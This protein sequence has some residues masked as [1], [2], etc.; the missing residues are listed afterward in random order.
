MNPDGRLPTS[1]EL[2]Y[3]HIAEQGVASKAELLDRF[4]IPSSTLTRT[5][6]EMTADGLIQASGLGPSSGGRRPI[7]YETN[8][9]YGYFFGLEISRFHSSLGFFDVRMNPMSFT[10]WR[11]DEAMTPDKLIA[12]V[13]QTVKAILYDHKIEPGQ[14]RGIGIGAVGPLDRERG[15]VLRP[16]YFAAPGWQDVPICRMAEE[17]T[18]FAARLENGA[19]A[20]LMGERWA[21]RESQPQHMLYVHAGVGLRSALMSNGAVVHGSIDMEGAVG[22]MIVQ[23]DGPRLQEGG[24]FGALEAYASIQA[25]EKQARSLAKLGGGW[26][27]RLRLAPEQIR[28]EDLLQA[29]R[30]GYPPAVELF[31]RA[32]AYLGIGLANMINLFHPETVILGGSLIYADERFY[33]TAIDAARQNVY[34]YP[35]YQPVF[36]KGELREDAVATGAAL[37]MWRSMEI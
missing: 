35:A 18:G 10:R 27:E 28:Y 36:T 14:V 19:N 15:A 6:E 7:L 23:A 16:L 17:A 8:P 5:L 26:A 21:L 13:A 34:Y 4:R 3:R 2:I 33:R 29:L 37:M 22:Q 1:K 12:H 32:A 20:A 11:M 31:D 9:A 30:Q 25:L 24:N